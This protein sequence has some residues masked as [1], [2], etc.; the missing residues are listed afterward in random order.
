MWGALS[1]ERTSLSLAR[2]TISRNF[3]VLLF[4]QPRHGSHR[5]SASKNSYIALLF[6]TVKMCFPCRCL[7]IDVFSESAI[8]AFIRRVA[9]FTQ[10]ISK[11]INTTYKEIKEIYLSY[12]KY[13]SVQRKAFRVTPKYTKFHLDPLNIFGDVACWSKGGSDIL[14]MSSVSVFCARNA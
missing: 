10:R 12:L 1:E 5:K 2:V 3:P 6:V 7:A 14:H 13:F 9:I 8:T 11:N 4:T